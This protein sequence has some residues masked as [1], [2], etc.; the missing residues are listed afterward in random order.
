MARGRGTEWRVAEA[1][2]ASPRVVPPPRT[3]KRVGLP[4]AG[5]VCLHTRAPLHASRFAPARGLARSDCR[6]QLGPAL[7]RPDSCRSVTVVAPSFA[8]AATA[9]DCR[10]CRLCCRLC[11]CYPLHASGTT[12]GAATGEASGRSPAEAVAA[13]PLP[14]VASWGIAR[15]CIGGRSCPRARP[16]VPTPSASVHA[17][18]VC[19]GCEAL[20]PEPPVRSG[21]TSSPRLASACM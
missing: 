17:V 5:A 1:G 11:C 2:L 14:P 10:Y 20:A 21:N 15:R 13:P 3:P 12:A 19:C 9:A 6:L 8:A 18:R 7:V 4:F 16:V